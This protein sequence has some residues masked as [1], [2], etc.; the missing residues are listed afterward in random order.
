MTKIMLVLFLPV[1]VRAADVAGRWNLRL[2][3]FGEEYGASRI[4]LK[5]E[6][7][8]LTGTLNELKL[9]G[10]ADSDRVQ[11]TATRPDGSE[12]GKF[13]GRVTGDAIEGTVKQGEDEFA[14]KAPWP[15]WKARRGHRRLSWPL[16]RMH[17]GQ[18]PG[19]GARCA[20]VWRLK[21]VPW[22]R[23]HT[24]ERQYRRPDDTGRA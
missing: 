6:G 8:R 14:W 11:F 20:R 12:W 13:E 4:E 9:A 22:P 5:T 7:T 1:L 23:L 10:T 15:L 18:R 2:V 21:N 17:R 24:R 3:R 19:D 16:W